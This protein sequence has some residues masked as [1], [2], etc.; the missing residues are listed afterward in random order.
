MVKKIDIKKQII[1]TS[2]KLFSKYGYKKVSMQDIANYLHK[3][4]GSLY[5]YFN[6]KEEIFFAIVDEDTQNLKKI[7]YESVKQQDGAE[8]KLRT[9]IL[10][11][12]KGY[13]RLSK[14]YEALYKDIYIDYQLIEQIRSYY[15]KEEIATIKMILRKGVKQKTFDSNFDIN[16]AAIAIFCTIKGFGIIW[17]TSRGNDDD[18]DNKIKQNEKQNEIIN[19]LLQIL[20]DGIKK[21]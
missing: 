5:Y 13:E 4:K 18:D 16:I 6:N 11:R 14:V 3:T 19:T 17:D 21:R 20:F 8:D 7:L 2:K 10:T 15:E 9:Y 1:E 12:Q